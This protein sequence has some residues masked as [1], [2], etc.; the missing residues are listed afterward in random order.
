[1]TNKIITLIFAVLNNTTNNLVMFKGVRR[2]KETRESKEFM[3]LEEA[4]S[5]L[6]GFCGTEEKKENEVSLKDKWGMVIHVD[7]FVNV[8]YFQ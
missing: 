8:K 6:E 1:M 7:Q 5:F 4:I 3:S 2:T